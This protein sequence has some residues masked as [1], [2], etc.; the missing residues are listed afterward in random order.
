MSLLSC[1][2]AP[3][4]TTV[5]EPMP[6]HVKGPV[7]PH[8][9]RLQLYCLVIQPRI[10]LQKKK[11]RSTCDPCFTDEDTELTGH[12][13]T[14]LP[15]VLG[16][17]KARPL[18]PATW[19]EARNGGRVVSAGMQSAPSWERT[20]QGTNTGVPLSVARAADPAS[21][22]GYTAAASPGAAVLYFQDNPELPGMSRR[23]PGVS[24]P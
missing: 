18:G 21:S 22:S 4:D 19:L 17:L 15:Q 3:A 5:S 9:L 16:G 13:G 6:S 2:V 24:A 7:S 12:L 1:R 23:R 8:L 11:K 20:E 14:H 10:I